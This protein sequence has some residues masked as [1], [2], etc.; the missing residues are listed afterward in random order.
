MVTKELSFKEILIKTI[1]ND[2][3]IGR[4]YI[5]NFL[6]TKYKLP[7]IIDEIFYVLKTGIAWR[8]LRS[9]INWQSVYYHFKR[10]VSNDIFKKFYLSLRMQY[11]VT[12]I[13]IFNNL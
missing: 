1:I 9:S 8:A 12:S 6:H 2:T 11:F 13:L 4:F 5:S 10:F 7:D 3:N